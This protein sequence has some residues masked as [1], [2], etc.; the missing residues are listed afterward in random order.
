MAVF[1]RKKCT[2]LIYSDGELVRRYTFASVVDC[3]AFISRNKELL[4]QFTYEIKKV[5]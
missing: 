1:N 4:N 5:A 3:N 2:L